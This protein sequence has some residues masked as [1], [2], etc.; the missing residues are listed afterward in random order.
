MLHRDCIDTVSLQFNGLLLYRDSIATIS[1]LKVAQVCNGGSFVTT[2]ILHRDSIASMLNVA[3]C[4]GPKYH[5]CDCY[6]FFS[7]MTRIR[8]KTHN[9]GILKY[10]ITNINVYYTLDVTYSQLAYLKINL[11]PP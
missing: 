5:L 8:M 3:V 1:M 7:N 2:S 11:Y 4:K 6:I 10:I 9:K